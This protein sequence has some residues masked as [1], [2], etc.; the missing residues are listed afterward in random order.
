MLA[1]ALL[2]GGRCRL[3][4][5]AGSSDLDSPVITG[6][7]DDTGVEGDRITSDRL[8]TL[9]GTAGAGLKVEVYKGNSIL[10]DTSSR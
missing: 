2:V 5:H 3:P 9:F 10:G 6:F 1:G 8:L 4:A 7:A